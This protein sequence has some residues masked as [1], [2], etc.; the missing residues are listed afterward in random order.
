[1]S[2]EGPATQKPDLKIVN[3]LSA[4]RLNEIICGSSLIVCRS[5]YTSIMDF[6]KLQKKAVLI[7]TPGQKEQEYLA[8]YLAKEKYFLIKQQEAFD[9]ETAW[10][11][12]QSFDFRFPQ[13]DFNKYKKFIAKLSGINT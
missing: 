3:H 13:I 8:Q 7:P 4:D 6:V 5:G 1:M 10:N 9:L 11:E 12:A 2:L